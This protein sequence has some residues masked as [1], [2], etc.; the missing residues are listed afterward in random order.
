MPSLV[1]KLNN[2]PVDEAE[3]VRELLRENDIPFYETP[4]GFWG[5]SL[6]AIWLADDQVEHQATAE[7]LIN[8]YQSERAIKA[9]A[10]YQPKS[11]LAAFI[12][13]PLRLVLVL[14]I[15]VIVYF[16]VSPFVSPIFA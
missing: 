9:Q 7:Q 8:T 4:Q 3:E 6:A 5:F 14:A 13:K 2:V 1:F 11:I 12:E 16:S 10:E 15:L